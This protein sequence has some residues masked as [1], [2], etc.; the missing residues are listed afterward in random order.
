MFYAIGGLFDAHEL[1]ALREAVAAL[2]YE[3]GAKTAGA[4]A[5]PVKRNAQAAPS[6]ARDAVLKKAEAALMK[7]GDFVSAARP[8]GFARML[9]SRIDGGGHYGTHVDAI[10]AGAR[11]DLSFTIFLSDPNSYLGAAPAIEDRIENRAFKLRAGEAVLYP[12][13]TL[14]RVEEVSEGTRLAIVG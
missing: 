5:R 1:A 9:I 10:I 11:A 12:S 8:K 2:P 7:N 6:P 3:D 14:H 13:D 4:L